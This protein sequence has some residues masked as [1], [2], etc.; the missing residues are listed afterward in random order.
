PYSKDQALA[1]MDAAG[2][3][4]AVIQPP[5]WDPD[6]NR[7]GV[8]AAAAQPQRF[9]VLQFPAGGSRGAA[10]LAE[11]ERAARHARPALH[12]QRAATC[13]LARRRRARVAV[14]RRRAARHP[15]RARRCRLS[16]AARQAGGPASAAAPDRRSS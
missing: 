4:A 15:D 2:V 9:A 7:I 16:A 3:D 14:V 8:E 12:L 11:L 1:E 6:A 13:A 5:A 10:A